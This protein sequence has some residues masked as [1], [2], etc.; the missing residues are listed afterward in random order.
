MKKPIP[1]LSN[2]EALEVLYALCELHFYPRL[3]PAK[4]CQQKYE[5][6]GIPLGLL[7]HA[8]LSVLTREVYG[9]P[10]TG[11]DSHL[12][13]VCYRAFAETLEHNQEDGMSLNYCAACRIKHLEAGKIKEAQA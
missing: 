13:E 7:V 2:K 4:R 11:Q 5:E 9:E 6:T 10:G 12:C 8:A 3:L 1:S